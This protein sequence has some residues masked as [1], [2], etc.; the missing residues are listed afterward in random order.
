[1]RL[2]RI[3]IFVS[4][5][6]I[7]SQAGISPQQKAQ[8]IERMTTYMKWAIGTMEYLTIAKDPLEAQLTLKGSM[9]YV[10][11]ENARYMKSCMQAGMQESDFPASLKNLLVEMNRK[12]AAYQAKFSHPKGG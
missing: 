7:N 12:T 3:M 1:M 2:I 9:Q 6:P 10:A 4:L 5:F 8:C 11:Q